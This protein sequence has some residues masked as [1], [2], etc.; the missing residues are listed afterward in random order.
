[1]V[2]IPKILKISLEKKEELAYAT[3]SEFEREVV[4]NDKLCSKLGIVIEDVGK[5]M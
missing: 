2:R 4:I 3:I 1:M 5:E